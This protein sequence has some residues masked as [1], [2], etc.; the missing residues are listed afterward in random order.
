MPRACR[1]R[2]FLARPF[3]LGPT[4]KREA[5]GKIEARRAGVDFVALNRAAWGNKSRCWAFRTR[6]PQASASATPALLPRVSRFPKRRNRPTGQPHRRRLFLPYSCPQLRFV[7]NGSA[8]TEAAPNFNTDFGTPRGG[9]S[10]G[11]LS[12]AQA[13]PANRFVVF[14]I[15]RAET[16]K[17]RAKRFEPFAT[18]ASASRSGESGPF[19]L[20]NRHPLGM[21]ALEIHVVAFE[22]PALRPNKSSG[23]CRRAV[24][25]FLFQEQTTG[26]FWDS[27]QSLFGCG[28]SGKRL[29]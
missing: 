9:P 22:P 10:L 27:S 19:S 5:G 2:P 18:P 28:D 20:P 17:S 16:S 15:D 8:S 12:R 14:A 4:A 26:G 24:V 1:Q 11:P 23:A 13:W 3:G 6:Q 7:A 29:V 25:G 21:R